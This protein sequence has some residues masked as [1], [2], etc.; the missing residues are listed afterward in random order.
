MSNELI[1]LNNLFTLYCAKSK[2]IDDYDFG[3]VPFVT[4]AESNNGVVGYV[5]PEEDDHVFAGPAIAISG[6][7]HATVHFGEFLPKGN[8][9]DSLTILKPSEQ[10]L[11]E[12]ALK[13]W[14]QFVKLAFNL[15]VFIALINALN[16]SISAL[17]RINKALLFTDLQS[18]KV[19]DIEKNLLVCEAKY[20]DLLIH[21]IS[22]EDLICFAAAF[23]TLHKW[24]FSYGRKCSIN[25]LKNL[26]FP[27]PLPKISEIWNSESNLASSINTVVDEKIEHRIISEAA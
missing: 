8:G 6:L 2:G 3:N 17:V 5:E 27:F 7:G 11:T 22:V 14:D 13:L 9:G 23:N 19:E 15:L 24:R 20:S 25:R 4:S 1:K 26:Q 16:N 12:E 18:Q 21:G 10:T